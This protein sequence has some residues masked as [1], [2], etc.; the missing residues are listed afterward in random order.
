MRSKQVNKFDIFINKNI[1]MTRLLRKD[2]S[3]IVTPE[4]LVILDKDVIVKEII[5]NNQ[6]S[7]LI[8]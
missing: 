7:H 8:I 1:E 5:S 6:N 2:I 4:K 3:K